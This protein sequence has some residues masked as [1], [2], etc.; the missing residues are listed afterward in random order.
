MM[1]PAKE[2]QGKLFV[3]VEQSREVKPAKAGKQRMVT[4]SIRS[5]GYVKPYNLK[6]KMYTALMGKL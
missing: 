6:G 5:A 1:A 4:N 3:R 2:K